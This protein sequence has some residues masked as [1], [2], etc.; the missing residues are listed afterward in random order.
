MNEVV[1]VTCAV[2]FLAYVTLVIMYGKPSD[3]A[4]CCQRLPDN[5]NI[6]YFIGSLLYA[7]IP[8]SALHILSHLILVTA[9]EIDTKLF[10][11][12]SKKTEAWV[13]LLV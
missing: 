6:N 7:H 4:T 8:L 2:I 11:F 3:W 5:Y 13:R 12:Y 10:L 9:Y 1:S